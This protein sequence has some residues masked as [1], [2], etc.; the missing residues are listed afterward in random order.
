MCDK[1]VFDL[2]QEVEGSPNVFIRKDWLN[3]LDNMNGN[4]QSNQSVID[5]SQ[6]SNSNKWMNYREAYLAVPLLL[7]LASSTA[8]AATKTTNINDYAIGLKNWFGSV[9]HSFTLDYNG[10]TIIQQTPFINMWNMFKLLTTLS[11]NDIITQGSVIGFYPDDATSFGYSTAA[12]A[13]GVGVYNNI[14]ITNAN[15]TTQFT[16]NI[17]SA[18]NN[19]LTLRTKNIAFEVGAVYSPF[20]T[21]ETA[22]QSWTSNIVRGAYAKTFIATEYPVQQISVMAIIYLKHITSFFD[23]SPLLKGAFMKMTMNLNNGT[24][25]VVSDAAD[26]T[27]FN[28]YTTNVYSGGIFPLVVPSI[29]S[30]SSWMTQASAVYTAAPTFYYNL[31]VGDV[32][33]DSTVKGITGVSTGNISKNIYL[34]VPA[35]TFNPSFEK[36]YLDSSPKS[37]KYTDVYQYQVLDIAAGSSFNNLITNG[38]AN[39]KSVLI[40]PFL[41]KIV[42]IGG[43]AAAVGNQWQSPFDTAGCGTTAP[44]VFLN[45]FN[46]QISGQNA[47]YNTQRYNYEEFVNQLYGQNAV[48]GGLTDGLT[49]GLIDYLS[50]QKSQCFYYVNVE[51][52]LPVERSVPKSVQILGTNTSVQNLNFW[53]FVEYESEIKIDLWTGARV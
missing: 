39:I 15:L 49:S 40:I 20:M 37:I 36:A 10:T 17:Y 27:V 19:G 29:G 35:Y 32:C 21:T 2:S 48:N 5:T 31:S 51:R 47:I 22:S 46:V 8:L 43:T 9:I 14:M 4:Y 34:Y 42:S 41:S 13:Y 28:S 7:T 33:L 23:F 38:I 50:F 53:V 44:L 1:L 6:L 26:I 24:A 12:S 11:Y 30:G 18:G 25:S 45:N 3:I 16:T 52:M